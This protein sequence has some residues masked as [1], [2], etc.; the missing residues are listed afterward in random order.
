MLIYTSLL[1]ISN[2]LHAFYKQRFLYC[3]LFIFLTFTS[4]LFYSLPNIYT[5]YFDKLAILFVVSY[6]AFLL[7]FKN[8]FQQFVIS[9]TFLCTVFFYFF[10][11]LTQSFCFGPDGEQYHAA[12]HV[13]SSLGHHLI[14]I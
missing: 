9:L 13:I 1:F 11:F 8:T 2:A 7:Y 5:K 3:L 6:G 4:V 14:L 10:G 12:L